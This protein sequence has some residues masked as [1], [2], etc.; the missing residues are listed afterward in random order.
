M[1]KIIIDEKQY[2]VDPGLTIIQAAER[3]GVTIPHFC[4]HS[5]LPV[6]GNCRMCLV[7]V[8]KM[9]KLV[10]ACATMVTDGMVVRTKS[11]KV[12]NAQQAVMEFLLINH[13]L[14]CPIC[15][16]AGECELQDYAYKY[17]EGV[18]RFE[19][20]K[21]RK[22]KRVELG[23]NV[24]LDVERCIMCSRCI[25]FCDAIAKKPQLTFTQRN[26]HIVLTTFPGEKL[27][28]PYSMNTIDLCPVGALTSKQFRFKARVWEMSS[29]ESVCPGCARGCS[30]NLWV[31]NNEILRVAPRHNPQ[32][33]D[34]WMCDA[35][36][37]E[38]FKHVNA[39]NR[40]KAPMIRRNDALVEVGW[41]EAVSKVVSELKTFKKQ[42]IAGI[43]SPFATNEDN[44]VFIKFM[45]HLGV[46]NLDF[47][48]RVVDGDEDDLL[49]RADKTPNG[50]GAQLVGVRSTAGSTRLAG[51]IRGIKDGHIKALY[52]I[53]D[54]IASN[55]AMAEVL[56][57]LDLFIVH[58]SIQNATTEFA[59]VILSSA[60]YAEMHGTFTNFQGQVQRIRPAV[61][62]AEQDRAL[63]GLSMS[64]LDRF[65]A[66]NDRWTKGGKRDARPTWRVLVSVANAFGAKWRFN[67]AEDVFNEIASTIDSFKGMKYLQIGSAGM[68]LNKKPEL[69][70][71]AR[72]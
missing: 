52:C 71:T 66:P 43:G 9:P 24:V 46:T 70:A 62:T 45:R 37:L 28:N 34:Y 61:A 6:A 32:I 42:E 65:G 55:R 16:E 25:R 18:S 68:Q 54:S 35:G 19:F 56:S 10:I 48:D 26:D 41:D 15:D 64:R 4:W 21:V 8:E 38:S 63:D 30:V 33:N 29:T 50:L 39:E 1:P 72:G 20:E 36:R 67:T 57:K 27:D 17:S 44:Y 69:R 7:E 59:D 23:P 12:V 13:P 3:N 11:L 31:R 5:C 53:D 14:D 40:V 58:A 22:P 2:E 51:I 47:M 60:T 49:V